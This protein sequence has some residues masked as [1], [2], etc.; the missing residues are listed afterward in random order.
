MRFFVKLLFL[1]Q[2]DILGGKTGSIRVREENHFPEFPAVPELP[3]QQMQEG[4]Y[5]GVFVL[6]L[7]AVVRPDAAAGTRTRSFRTSSYFSCRSLNA[8][9]RPP[10]PIRV[11]SSTSLDCTFRTYRIPSRSRE[12]VYLDT[13]YLTPSCARVCL[14]SI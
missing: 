8:Q 6:Q 5:F 14:P 3:E 1:A 11:M 4:V 9:M 2:R 7:S 10:L 13:P 12:W